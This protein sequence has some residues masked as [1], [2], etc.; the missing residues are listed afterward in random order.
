MTLNLLLEFFSQ[1]LLGDKTSVVTHYFCWCTTLPNNSHF[2]QIHNTH[3]Y[4]TYVIN[5]AFIVCILY[6]SLTSWHPKVQNNPTCGGKTY[7]WQP[8]LSWSKPSTSSCFNWWCLDCVPSCSILSHI[9][10]YYTSPFTQN[11]TFT[12][13]TN[14]KFQQ[15]QTLEFVYQLHLF[16]VMNFTGQAWKWKVLPIFYW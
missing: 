9:Y 8:W 13:W 11:A 12:T 2:N 16:L 6:F 5:H 4:C 15:K 1:G 3:T 7:I 10:I 14:K